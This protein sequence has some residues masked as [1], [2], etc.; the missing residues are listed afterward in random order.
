MLVKSAQKHFGSVFGQR[1]N[2][3][4]KSKLKKL[5]KCAKK[6]QE[7][8][9]FLGIL[10]CL[11][12]SQ[13]DLHFYARYNF[14]TWKEKLLHASYRFYRKC[15]A[16]TDSFYAISIQNEWTMLTRSDKFKTWEIDLSARFIFFF[17]SKI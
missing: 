16:K 2:Y 17:K 11:L 15:H 9:A 8:Q 14:N 5:K 6:N 13:Y 10:A 3:P 1:K 7:K 4:K 12:G